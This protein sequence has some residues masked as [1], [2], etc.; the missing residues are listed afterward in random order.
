MREEMPIGCGEHECDDYMVECSMCGAEF[1]SLCFPNSALCPDCAASVSLDDEDDD[2][3]FEDVPNL[4]Q[5]ISE[6]EDAARIIGDE[7]E[8]E[9]EK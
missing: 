2:P 6:D 8:E 3:D 9:K 7:D 4:N 1:C 5:L